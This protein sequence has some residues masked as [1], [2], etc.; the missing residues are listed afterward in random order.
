MATTREEK[1][2]EKMEHL[3]ADHNNPQAAVIEKQ[4]NELNYR[5]KFAD[6][7]AAHEPTPATGKNADEEKDEQ[8]VNQNNL[9]KENANQQN[10]PTPLAKKSLEEIAANVTEKAATRLGSEIGDFFFGVSNNPATLPTL[11]PR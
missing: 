2:L 1:L 9:T 4:L 6:K 5:A 8:K 10:I 3:K 11:R 7:F